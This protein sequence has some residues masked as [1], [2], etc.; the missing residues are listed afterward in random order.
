MNQIATK[1]EALLQISSTINFTNNSISGTVIPVAEGDIEL[2]NLFNEQTLG[3][4][5]YNNVTPKINQSSQFSLNLNYDGNNYASYQSYI[6]KKFDISKSD[7][8]KSHDVIYEDLYLSKNNEESYG[9]ELISFVKFIRV[10]SENNF[11][12]DNTIVFFSQKYCE[13][14]IQYRNFN[15]YIL[16]AK[17]YRQDENKRKALKELTGWLSEQKEQGLDNLSIHKSELFAIV[18]TEIID[19]LYAVDIKDRIFY[20]LKNIDNILQDIKSKYSLYLEDFKYSKFIEK[21]NKHV[22]EFLVKINKVIA[23]LQTQVLAIPLAI[24]VITVFK[25]EKS[26]NVYIYLA[27]LVYLFMVLYSTFQQ[28]Y[29]LLQIKDQLENFAGKTKLPS[30]LA[31]TWDN[32]IKPVNNK[33][34]WHSI[35]LCLI[36]LFIGILIG[37]CF[38]NII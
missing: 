29:N 28:A 35:Y 32:E 37:I 12:K 4:F 26:V 9:D 11:H 2:I 22:D 18:S 36:T 31:E 7:F 33:I 8:V 16:L 19:S 30:D 17:N 14:N 1:I 20:L 6:E 27:F 38:Y 21:I 24:S 3:D 5:T 23:D 15:E 25:N 34:K 13:V 10:L